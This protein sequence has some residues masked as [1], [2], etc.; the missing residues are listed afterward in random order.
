MSDEN[1]NKWKQKGQEYFDHI[2]TRVSNC[3]IETDKIEQIEKTLHLTRND[4]KSVAEDKSIETYSKYA[5]IVGYNE[6]NK[7]DVLDFLEKLK[8]VDINRDEVDINRDEGR[9]KRFI[10]NLRKRK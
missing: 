6:K 8:T 9:I 7:K 2:H 3:D 10:K 5:D 4:F 1:I